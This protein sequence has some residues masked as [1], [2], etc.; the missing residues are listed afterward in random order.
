M[1]IKVFNELK[2]TWDLT[3]SGLETPRTTYVISRNLL[4]ISIWG[5]LGSGS[6]ALASFIFSRSLVQESTWKAFASHVYKAS[7][8]SCGTFAAVRAYYPYQLAT[9]IR[10]LDFTEAKT[11][12]ERVSL[13]AKYSALVGL[14]G[15]KAAW[16]SQFVTSN[17]QV[18][19]IAKYSLSQLLGL[20]I[21]GLTLRLFYNWQKGMLDK[22]KSEKDEV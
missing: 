12:N 3:I 2:Q 22:S 8:A 4:R 5:A 6:A 15:A 21:A 7:L 18:S 19:S 14:L 13:I 17:A 10:H 20:G 11:L 1:A 16:A 9:I